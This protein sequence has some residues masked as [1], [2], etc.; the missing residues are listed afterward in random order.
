MAGA[1]K[2]DSALVVE[3]RLD[4]P[5][6]VRIP[7]L[8]KRHIDVSQAFDRATQVAGLFGDL[9]RQRQQNSLDL[10]L[11][12][13][14]ELLESIVHVGD[15]KRLHKHRLTTRRLIV[16]DSRHLA[17][18]LRFHRNHIPAIPH[19]D[20]WFLQGGA[21]VLGR[22]DAV[23]PL[24]QSSLSCVHLVADLAQG[25]AGAVHDVATIV[26]G[27]FDGLLQRSTFHHALGL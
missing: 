22:N 11:F 23:E 25:R 17:A 1:A 26:E 24:H 7:G 21:I 6:G 19:G 9:R 4:C 12:V 14:L 5:L 8:C 13:E 15:D 18:S 16:D 20:D 27:L 10:S 3:L 2:R